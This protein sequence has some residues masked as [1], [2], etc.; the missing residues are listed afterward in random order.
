MKVL[1]AEADVVMRFKILKS[2]ANRG[3][4]VDMAFND[5]SVVSLLERFDYSLLALGV[6]F[7]RGSARRLVTLLREQGY[8]F[9]VVHLRYVKQRQKKWPAC[10][11]DTNEFLLSCFKDD[12]LTAYRVAV[13]KIA[14]LSEYLSPYLTSRA[15]HVPAA[16][17]GAFNDKRSVPLTINSRQDMKPDQ[18]IS[19]S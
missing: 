13:F 11:R 10:L 4:L 9:P 7:S 5:E 8:G 15:Q 18:E 17:Y 6:S 1:F 2:V 16:E 12:D 14:G 3:Y 19:L